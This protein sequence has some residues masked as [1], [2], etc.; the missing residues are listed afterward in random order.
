M[1]SATTNTLS[2]DNSIVPAGSRKGILFLKDR[3]ADFRFLFKES[4]KSI[5]AHRSILIEFSDVFDIMLSGQWNETNF[6]EIEDASYDAFVEFLQFLYKPKVN[7]SM[8]NI[9]V[10]VYLANKYNV[11]ECKKLCAQ[12]IREA[13][14]LDNILDVL[15][16]AIQFDLSEL[17]DHC[18]QKISID[19][20]N[21]LATEGFLQCSKDV[22]KAIL[23]LN[24]ANCDET[25]MFDACSMWAK[26]ACKEKKNDPSNENI[27]EELGD[28]FHAIRFLA[29]EQ[30]ELD[31][32]IKNN[33]GLFT[34]HE[35][36]DLLITSRTDK[37]QAEIFK[38][39]AAREMPFEDQLVKC[40][41]D[42]ASEDSDSDSDS[43]SIII[44]RLMFKL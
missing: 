6:T 27:R 41:L 19:T 2:I 11:K 28:L 37:S 4:G 22:L 24:T 1:D 17:K 10:V 15:N 26:H 14:N 36:I 35:I 8:E 21:I 38:N 33:V 30:E 44:P 9:S 12:M 42:I 25:E 20:S 23:A 18:L 32:Y 3:F 29:M 43:D 40:E 34:I 13:L 39:I 16:L 31:D 5:H 7:V